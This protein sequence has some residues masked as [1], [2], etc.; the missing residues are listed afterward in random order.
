MYQFPVADT[1]REASYTSN[2]KVEGEPRPD[3]VYALPTKGNVEMIP[4]TL[5]PIGIST[6]GLMQ[7]NVMCSV[8]KCPVMTIYGHLQATV[9]SYASKHGRRS[10]TRQL[11]T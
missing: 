9:R 10:E 8:D 5:L 4:G 1:I 11:K 3:T 7:D 2:L 6:C